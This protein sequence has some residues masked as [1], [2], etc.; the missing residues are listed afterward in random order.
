M[1]NLG[2]PPRK[3]HYIPRFYLAGFCSP[4][5]RPKGKELLW[6]YERGREPR[7]SVPEAEAHQK[8]FYSFKENGE[9]NID[10]E[11]WF[12]RMEQRIAPLLADLATS[13]REPTAAER[14]C[15]AAFMGTMYT[16]TPL[17]RQMSDERFGPATSQMLKRAA[18]DPVEFRKLYFSVETGAPDEETAEQVRQ[19]ILSGRSDALEE[20]E[21]FR[22]ASIIHV[23]VTVGEVL[24]EMGWQFIRAPDG[25]SFITSD[26][27]L[28]CE[29]SEPGSREIHFRS[30]V[31]LPNAAAWF[32]LTRDVCLLTQKGLTPGIATTSRSTARA[33]NK[34]ILL[35]AERRIYA[36]E[37]SSRLQRA[38]ERHGCKVPLQSLDLTYEG[39]K[40]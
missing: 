27:P 6:V 32:P 15:L 9:R 10:T 25:H 18:A 1:S 26:N 4:S 38:F 30:G 20:R 28:V 40:I 39:Q 12:A 23:G 34:R 3:H 5:A 16:R 2:K 33:I 17:G 37:N 11:N 19:D 8:D 29:V 36:G 24:C 7:C 13:K 35:C 31:N 21:D 22:L 14:T